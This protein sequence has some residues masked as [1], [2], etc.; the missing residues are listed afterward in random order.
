MGEV[1]TRMRPIL[2]LTI[3]CSAAIAWAASSAQAQTTSVTVIHGIDGTDLGLDE[4]LPVD[5]HVSGVGCALTG[6]VFRQVSDRLELPS[7]SY[8]TR[9]PDDGAVR[10]RGRGGRTGCRA[11]GR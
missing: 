8:D 9:R 5:V 2:A 11:R 7:G 4:P 6:C 1:M 3:A 10:G